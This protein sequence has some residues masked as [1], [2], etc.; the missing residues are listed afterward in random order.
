[1]PNTLIMLSKWRNFDKSGHTGDDYHES[2][3]QKIFC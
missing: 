2:D 3:V 1:M